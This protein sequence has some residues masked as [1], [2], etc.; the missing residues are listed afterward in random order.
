V[1]FARRHRA[2][3]TACITF[4]ALLVALMIFDY[5]MF[6]AANWPAWSKNGRVVLPAIDRTLIALAIDLIFLS[7]W[8]TYLR[9]SVRVANTFV[10]RDR[11]EPRGSSPPTP[12][13]IRVRIRRFNGLGDR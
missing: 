12:P 10:N 1:L 9:R 5:A 3:P 4:L 6:V 13:D 11:G 7:I 8:A 2:F